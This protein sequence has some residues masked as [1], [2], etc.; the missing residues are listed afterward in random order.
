MILQL[1]RETFEDLSAAVLHTMYGD[2]HAA[3][4]EVQSEGHATR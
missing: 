3:D 4:S 2:R 1:R